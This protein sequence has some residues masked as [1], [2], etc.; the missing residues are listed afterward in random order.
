MSSGR[1]FKV[2]TDSGVEHVAIFPF[3]GCKTGCAL[4]GLILLINRIIFKWIAKFCEWRISPGEW[5]WICRFFEPVP[6]LVG[7]WQPAD[8]GIKSNKNPVSET[9]ILQPSWCCSWWLPLCSWFGIKDPIIDGITIPIDRMIGYGIHLALSQL[10][11]C[12][13]LSIST[14]I[15]IISTYNWISRT[16]ISTYY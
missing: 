16:A 11:R 1:L 6:R 4:V 12:I 15:S 9:Q 2:D 13:Q 5:Q 7:N 14:V 3:A 10:I 8:A